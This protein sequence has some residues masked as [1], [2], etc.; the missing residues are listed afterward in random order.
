M[1][2]SAHRICIVFAAAALA[3]HVFA[4]TQD[5]RD[6]VRVDDEGHLILRFVGVPET[7]LD[8]NQNE[9]VIN[10]FVSVMVHDRLRADISFEGE[11]V[12]SR[13]ADALTDSLTHY[14]HESAPETKLGL[15]ECRSASCRLVFELPNAWTVT[16][17]QALL[18]VAQRAIE[19]FI[20]SNPD[21]LEGSF[22]MAAYYQ[23]GQPQQIRAYL[24]RSGG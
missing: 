5:H 6:F 3:C 15:T 21:E 9:E 22:L 8:E 16:D 1:R 13:W 12:D 17:H 10:A 24:Q 4:Q 18:A 11:P 14:F 20:D 2:L 19:A 23:E 7:G